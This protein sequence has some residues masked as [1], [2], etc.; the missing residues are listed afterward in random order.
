MEGVKGPSLNI[1]TRFKFHQGR[2]RPSPGKLWVQTYNLLWLLG[3]GSQMSFF[4]QFSRWQIPNT[5]LDGSPALGLE[6]VVQRCSVQEGFDLGTNSA[7]W[8]VTVLFPKLNR[9][10]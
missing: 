2:F 3:F 7:I 8:L 6:K 5:A 1:D 4:G 9:R 10:S